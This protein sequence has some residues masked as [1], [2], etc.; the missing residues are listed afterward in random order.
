MTNIPNDKYTFVIV[1]IIFPPPIFKECT[2]TIEDLSKKYLNTVEVFVPFYF[3]LKNMAASGSQFSCPLN[4]GEA[5]NW[6][7]LK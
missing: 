4:I 1:F 7:Y 6:S 2:S 5:V 3:T